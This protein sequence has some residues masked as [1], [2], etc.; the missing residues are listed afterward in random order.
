[1]FLNEVTLLG[2]NTYAPEWRKSINGF[3]YLTAELWFPRYHKREPKQP[4]VANV[5]RRTG[6][7]VFCVMKGKCAETYARLVQPR[8]M[9]WAAGEIIGYRKRIEGKVDKL[10]QRVCVQISRWRG[11]WASARKALQARGKVVLD[12]TE[13][14]RLR[15]FSEG[16]SDWEVADSTLKNLG[17]NPADL[18]APERR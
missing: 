10:E 16:A 2:M 12:R 15:S 18:G 9:I 14:E 13:Y 4:K 3:D 8:D 7:T 1:M 17:I 5:I 6:F 11:L